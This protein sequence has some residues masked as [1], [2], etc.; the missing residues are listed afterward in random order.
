MAATRERL[1]G[2]LWG[3]RPD[4]QARS[5]LRQ[6]LAALRKELDDADEAILQ[7]KDDTVRLCA[8]TVGVDVAAFLKSGQADEIESLREAARLYRGELLSDFGS[9]D[10]GFEGWLS[11]ERAQLRQE[12][13]RVLEKLA[14]PGSGDERLAVAQKLVSLDPLREASQRLL[15]H[16]QC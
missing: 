2:L 5:S 12:A 3:D 14:W 11:I 8:A 7:V 13:I 16:S 6:S 10:E 15:M 9:R 1:A 4:E